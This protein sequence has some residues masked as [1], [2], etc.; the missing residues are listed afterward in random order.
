[1][2]G[3]GVINT[4]NKINS[5]KFKFENNNISAGKITLYVIKIMI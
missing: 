1:M 4:S 2:T 3:G 5:I